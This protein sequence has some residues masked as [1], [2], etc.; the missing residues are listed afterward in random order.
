MKVSADRILYLSRVLAHEPVG[1]RLQRWRFR[2]A[3]MLRR[4]RAAVSGASLLLLSVGL[5]GH[6]N[7]LAAD[8]ESQFA[9]AA[10]EAA[11]TAMVS[12]GTDDFQGLFGATSSMES[13][14]PDSQTL[15]SF[16]SG[17]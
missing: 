17:T 13:P 4:Q 11:Q 10:P 9:P 12:V 16:H 3:L 7:R 8:I 2:V 14:S 6:S 1:T 5:L 15:W